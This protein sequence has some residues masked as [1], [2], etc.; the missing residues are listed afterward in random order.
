[1]TWCGSGS[2]V[3][4]LVPFGKGLLFYK[5]LAEWIL[6]LGHQGDGDRSGEGVT[7]SVSLGAIQ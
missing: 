5:P 4:T 7:P 1:M 3:V 2:A 6:A